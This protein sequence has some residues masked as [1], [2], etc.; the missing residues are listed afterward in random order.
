MNT[1][2]REYEQDVKHV[3]ARGWLPYVGAGLIA[4]AALIGIGLYHRNATIE[5]AQGKPASIAAINGRPNDYVGDMVT[6]NG[7]VV[8]ILSPQ[9]FSLTDTAGELLVWSPRGNPD[10]PSRP[11]HPTLAV[12]D[13]VRALGEIKRYEPPADSMKLNPMFAPF[14]GKVVLEAE[15]ASITGPAVLPDNFR[16]APPPRAKGPLMLSMIFHGLE[17]IAKAKDREKLVGARVQLN[18]ATVTRVVSDRGFWVALP[19][20]KRIFCRLSRAL[21]DGDMEWLIQVKKDQV[22]FLQGFLEDP[23]SRST[24]TRNW[25]LSSSEAREVSQ[26]ELYLKVDTIALNRPAR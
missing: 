22:G 3:G 16:S 15:T 23:P 12:G 6:V 26:F 9:Y 8:R 1:E 17:E 14:H 25:D 10:V 7:R 11:L 20:G 13:V 2:Y 21:D 4:L 19:N 24:M 5:A 18:S